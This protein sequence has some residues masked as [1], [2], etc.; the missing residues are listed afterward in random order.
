MFL[1]FDNSKI[2]GKGNFKIA[3]PGWEYFSNPS[4]E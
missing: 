1:W 2:I 4:H 3:A